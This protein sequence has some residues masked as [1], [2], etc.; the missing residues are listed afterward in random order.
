MNTLSKESLVRLNAALP[1]PRS[2]H[3][4][5][6]APTMT[7]LSKS[8]STWRYTP[9]ESHLSTRPGSS[10]VQRLWCPRTI[11]DQLVKQ[12]AP[13]VALLSSW[14]LATSRSWSLIKCARRLISSSGWVLT[15]T[16]SGCSVTPAK[17]LWII[18]QCMSDHP[19][20]VSLYNLDHKYNLIYSI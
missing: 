10:K 8:L 2:A 3:T 13:L 15:K 1:H 14:L 16:P 19:Y 17:A 7:T 18:R 12:T 6:V 9:A 4:T 5:Q 11:W 20:I